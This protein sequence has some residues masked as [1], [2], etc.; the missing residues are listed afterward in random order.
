MFPVRDEGQPGANSSQPGSRRERGELGVPRAPICRHRGGLSRCLWAGP[1]LGQSAHFPRFPLG[2]RTTG[3][4]KSKPTPS[5]KGD[6]RLESRGGRQL[7]TETASRGRRSRGV[8]VS[9]RNE[10]AG[11]V[12]DP[13][14]ESSRRPGRHT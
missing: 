8:R 3:L 4:Q 5:V 10:A 13:H 14:C 9:P 12:H 2:T 7:S 6:L 1:A 11:V